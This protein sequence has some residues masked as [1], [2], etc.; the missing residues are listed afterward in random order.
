M[1]Q[2]MKK[3]ILILF[4]FTSYLTLGQTRVEVQ[5]TIIEDLDL[6]A[7]SCLRKLCLLA[8]DETNLIQIAQFK[9]NKLFISNKSIDLGKYKKENDIEGLSNDGKYFYAIGSH[10]ISRKSFKYQK[11]RY[12]FFRILLD[13]NGNVI[14]LIK[15]NLK[16][17]LKNSNTFKPFYRKPLQENG[18]NIEG[19]AAYNGK[20]YIGYRAPLIE[21]KAIIESFNAKEFFENKTIL[22]HREE[23]ID[24]GGEGIRSLEIK[25]GEYFIIS[26]KSEPIDD[27]NAKL[28]RYKASKQQAIISES[29]PFAYLKLEGME[30]IGNKFIYLYD[31]EPNGNLLMIK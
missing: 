11:S 8:S 23:L 17:H 5:G 21:G 9:R 30:I 13:R 20:V 15:K 3:I 31:S 14:E 26:G 12:V 16:K 19:L 7:I 22:E 25:K 6:S 29:V 10:G 24:L 2:F 1:F 4:I 28:W 18:V 27:N